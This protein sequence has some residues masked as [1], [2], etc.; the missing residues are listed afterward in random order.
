V[1]PWSIGLVV[2]VVVGLVVIVFGAL[3]DR[4]KNQRR[5]SEMLAPP[6]RDIPQ[7]RPDSPAPAYLSEL[8]ARRVDELP[9][10]LS[11]AERELLARELKDA[12]TV[13]V[14]A[15]FA[16]RDYITD[17][18]SSRA[19]VTAPRVLVCG[20]RV[21]SIREL[22]G[23]LEKL[24]LSKTPLVVVA[25]SMSVEVH[26]TLEVNQIRQ[27]LS[28]V[29]V[30]VPDVSDLQLVADV[31]RA[32]IRSRSDLQAGYVWPEHLGGCARWVSEAKVSFVI[33]PAASLGQHR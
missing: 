5:A 6:K 1:E 17:R 4:A 19:V 30:V 2:V 22:L 23:V 20:D 18:S 13:R 27:T 7:F 21:E 9:A 28:L 14:D 33:G 16:S 11:A 3:S 8:Q 29:A 12:T 15:G 31:T 10:D 24:V 26:S 32:Q 25:P